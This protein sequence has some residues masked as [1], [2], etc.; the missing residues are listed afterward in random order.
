MFDDTFVNERHL[1]QWF[2]DEVNLRNNLKKHWRDYNDVELISGCSD[3]KNIWL[4]SDAQLLAIAKYLNHYVYF[5]EVED[6]VYS[7]LS[8]KWA[9]YTV[10]T[11]TLKSE[12]DIVNYC[13]DNNIILKGSEEEDV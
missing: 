4:N 5:E 9:S 11:I 12:A 13:Y 2:Y 1:A 3:I 8:F 7:K 10:R 6:D